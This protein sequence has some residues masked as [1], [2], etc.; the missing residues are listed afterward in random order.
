M[1]CAWEAPRWRPRLIDRVLST[2]EQPAGKERKKKSRINIYTRTAWASKIITDCDCRQSV[3]GLQATLV[4]SVVFFTHDFATHFAFNRCMFFCETG[5]E[6][7]NPTQ[8]GPMAKPTF[9]VS[10]RR[11]SR[12]WDTPLSSCFERSRV[13]GGVLWV[14]FPHENLTQVYLLLSALCRLKKNV[15]IHWPSKWYISLLDDR[16]TR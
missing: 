7:A 14:Q 13:I 4:I 3:T 15:Y 11:R 6:H 2:W 12:E 9:F 16:L 10:G 5:G 1:S 8:K